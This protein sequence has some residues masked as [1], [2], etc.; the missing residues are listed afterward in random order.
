MALKTDTQA[1]APD[2]QQEP[3]S[4]EDLEDDDFPSNKGTPSTLELGRTPSDR[5]AFFFG[6]SPSFAGD[7]LGSLHPL[8][9]QVPF[10]LNIFQ[11]NI[12]SMCLIVHMPSLHALTRKQLPSTSDSLSAPDEALLF[13]IYY[14]TITSMEDADVL[15]SFG[16]SKAE[17]NLKYRTGLERALAKA[18]F[19]NV[20]SLT[21][22]QALVIFLTLARRHDSPRYVLMVTSVVVRMAQV[23]GMHRDGTSFAHLSP[24]DVEMRRRV[25]WTLCVLDLRSSEDQ[26][27]DPVIPHGSFDTKIPLNINVSDLDPSFAEPPIERQGLTDMTVPLVWFRQVAIMAQMT[28]M[29]AKHGPEEGLGHLLQLLSDLGDTTERLYLQHAHPAVNAE[30]WMSVGVTRIIV[31]K[32]TLFMY[33]PRLFSSS[34]ST[35]SSDDNGKLLAA[36]VEIAELNHTLSASKECAPWRWIFQTYTHWHAIVFLLLAAS[37][38]E[39]SPVVERAWMALHS[40]W[41]IPRETTKAMMS[42]RTWVPLKKL[43]VQAKR[44][45]ESEIVRLKLDPDAAQ[46]LYEEDLRVQ[47]PTSAGFAALEAE[48]GTMQELFRQ[49]WRQLVAPDNIS[50]SGSSGMSQPPAAAVAGGGQQQEYWAGM[51]MGE[52][53]GMGDGDASFLFGDVSLSPGDLDI[54]LDSSMDWAQWIQSAEG[55][56]K[57][58]HFM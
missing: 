8:P 2:Q 9:S 33:L 49:R 18:D 13:A 38:E 25:W 23:L 36:A 11:E 26:N 41:L 5:H 57:Q 1:L 52:L 40:P 55:T 42:L 4:D 44:H 37:R 56:E 24:F 22:V 6:S 47:Q 12:N 50:Q 54:D 28:A 10:I 29:I 17:L 3:S 53:G 7:D 48:A 51:Q 35:T 32:M 58:G 34:S 27:I 16:A 19:L 20:S 14:A 21:L 15:A 45:R 46:R 30:Y 39:W 31:A 43:M